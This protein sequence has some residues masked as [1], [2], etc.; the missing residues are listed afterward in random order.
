MLRTVG[1][2]QEGLAELVPDLEFFE[3]VRVGLEKW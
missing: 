3:V 1:S 2:M